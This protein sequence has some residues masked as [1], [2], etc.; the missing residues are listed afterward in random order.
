MKIF[1]NACGPSVTYYYESGAHNLDL[2]KINMKNKYQLNKSLTDKLDRL[3]W[4][5]DSRISQ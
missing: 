1:E 3:L 2:D 4:N 5:K